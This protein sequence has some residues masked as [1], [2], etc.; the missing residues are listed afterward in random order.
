LV[1]DLS[2]AII[3]RQHMRYSTTLN[4]AT[5]LHYHNMV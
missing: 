4:G 5:S 3:H 1:F 2:E